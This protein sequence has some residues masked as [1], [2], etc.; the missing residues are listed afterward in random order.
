MGKSRVIPLLA[1]AWGV[2][3]LSTPCVAASASGGRS[4]SVSRTI[5]YSP[6]RTAN[7]GAP[8]KLSSTSAPA[9]KVA[10]STTAHAAPSVPT[11]KA[12]SPGSFWTPF[13]LGYMMAPSTSHAASPASK[14]VPPPTEGNPDHDHPASDKAKLAESAPRSVTGPFAI[15][16]PENELF[17]RECKIRPAAQDF[18][19]AAKIEHSVLFLA[20]PENG[21]CGKLRD[22]LAGLVSPAILVKS[23]TD[24][25][26]L[27]RLMK[28]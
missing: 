1:C 9:P 11:G 25:I 5:S 8:T 10:A 27:S 23:E 20:A 3:V 14:P 13:I 17:D 24:Q 12:S 18:I 2:L 21:R 4:V 28:Q 16:V 7:A 6:A 22:R 19:K 26:V 15:D